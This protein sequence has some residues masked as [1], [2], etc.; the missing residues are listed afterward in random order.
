MNAP[1]PEIVLIDDLVM[2][3]KLLPMLVQSRIGDMI[4][5]N[6]QSPAKSILSTA[7]AAT[8]APPQLLSPGAIEV[9]AMAVIVIVDVITDTCNPFF[10][11]FSCLYACAPSIVSA[12]NSNA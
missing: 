7:A 6:H 12:I 5:M 1:A 10:Y 9:V 4:T 8:V 3:T 2:P 11:S